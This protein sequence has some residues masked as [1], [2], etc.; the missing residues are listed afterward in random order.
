MNEQWLRASMIQVAERATVA[1]LTGRARRTSRRLAIRKA[2]V[3][4]AAVM[5]AVIGI[6]GAGWRFA[7]R[8]DAVSPAAPPRPD[9][10]QAAL[11]S[12]TA[13]FVTPG[14][15]TGT[16]TIQA[17][18][19]GR[20]R[21][22]FTLPVDS[23]RCPWNSVAISPDGTQ[24]SWVA[25]DGLS[26]SGTLMV[27]R[28]DGTQQRKVRGGVACWG[29]GWAQWTPD[30]R[31][32]LVQPANDKATPASI[33]DMATGAESP[34]PRHHSGMSAD[35]SHFYNRIGP[36]KF[37]I[38]DPAGKVLRTVDYVGR[39]TSGTWQTRGLSADGGMLAAD[40][41]FDVVRSF[42]TSFVID[43]KTG[44]DLDLPGIGELGLV[45]FLVDG[46]ALIQRRQGDQERLWLIS[47]TGAA[48][49]NAQQP[50]GLG[51]LFAYVP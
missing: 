17:L 13:Y 37:T 14:E 26:L 27:A 28:I 29:D 30:S 18:H 3:A 48:L 41:D 22:V 4:S 2:I 45:V 23:G 5:L 24:I 19:D 10:G 20:S 38:T 39:S 49:E 51:D 9:R 33:V 32:M 35:G 12:G 8:F 43:L 11:L 46:R 1:D 34:A 47:A 7:A 6:A 40:S 25:T 31:G 50:A 15:A 21:V 16:L 36:N 42:R 44:R